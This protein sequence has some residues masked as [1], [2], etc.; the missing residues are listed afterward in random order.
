MMGVGRTIGV[1]IV[2][3][4]HTIRPGGMER[5]EQPFANLLEAG[6]A[7]VFGISSEVRLAHNAANAL[8]KVVDCTVSVR[9]GLNLAG[10]ST[11]YS[12]LGQA[13]TCS[14]THRCRSAQSGSGRRQRASA[15]GRIGSHGQQSA[16]SQAPRGRQAY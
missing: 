7:L 1:T 14:W 11:T 12:C 10:D 5:A 2:L 16:P 8:V 13:A 6:L 4:A 3:G 9:R 15:R